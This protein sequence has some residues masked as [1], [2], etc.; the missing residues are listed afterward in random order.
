MN[1]LQMKIDLEKYMKNPLYAF[2][3]D[4]KLKIVDLLEKISRRT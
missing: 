4:T 1:R 2:Y 3:I